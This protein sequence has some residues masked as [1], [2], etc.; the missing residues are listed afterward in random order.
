[1]PISWKRGTLKSLISTAYIQNETIL[2]KELKH[3]KHGFH[4]IKRYLW[5]VIDQVST[6]SQ[7][8]INKDKSSANYPHAL[9][10]PVEKLHFL[11]FPYV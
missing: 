9:E 2:E 1:M 6:Y 11:I 8:K 7:E 10:Q 3:L 5:Q 4:K